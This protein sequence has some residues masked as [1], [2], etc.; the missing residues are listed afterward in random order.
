[1]KHMNLSV[2]LIG[3]FV[4]VSLITVIVGAIGVT[5]IRAV[6]RAD[7][8]MYEQ[9]VKPLTYISITS[10][11]FQAMRNMLRD[12]VINKFIYGKDIA[13]HIEGIQELDRKGLANLE[14]FG[15]AIE[16]EG[17]RHE[18][19]N[20]KAALAAYF[21]LREKLLSLIGEGKKEEAIAF[22]QGEIAVQGLKIAGA[23]D[24]LMEMEVN[25]AKSKSDQNTAAADGAVWF[26]LGLTG[27]GTLLAII[28]G[29]YLSLSITRPVLRVTA[30]LSEGAE[31]VAAASSQVAAASQNLAEGTSEQASSLEE[32]SSSMEELSS[33]TRQ[34][35]ENANQ[36]KVMMGQAAELVGKVDRSMTDM[37]A[38]IDEIS[39]SS[40]ET[41]KII[42][43]I[44]EIAFQTNLLALNAAVEAARAGEAGAGFAVVAD[45]VR[46]LAMR[47][48]EAAKNTSDLI[49]NTIKAVKKGHE[50]TLNTQEAFK[51]NTAIAVKI[52]QLIEEIATASQEQA[53]GIGQ[54]NVAVAEMDKVTQRSAANAEESASA[55]EEMNAQAEQMKVL[56]KELM[57][58]IGGQGGGGVPAPVGPPG[59]LPPPRRASLTST[60]GIGKGLTVRNK[61][62]FPEAKIVR[63][64]EVIPLEKDELSDF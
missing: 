57:A 6:A 54:I 20:L 63:P 41:G 62:G 10:S 42:K 13:H 12:A 33:M 47:A 44:D 34:N 55:S 24:K 45:E 31:Q 30:G 4:A 8:A 18:F 29:V 21:P 14:K 39:K 46:N 7:K 23:I 36:A 2:K 53:N 11:S 27:I 61:T 38:A 64:D 52:G 48:A 51:E 1:M 5:K 22:M 25:D 37:V 40:E 16:T 28:L 49:E 19:D 35:A 3:A 60:G 9:N 17:V 43:S 32:T 56:V 50:L 59:K 15:A 26:N 58:V